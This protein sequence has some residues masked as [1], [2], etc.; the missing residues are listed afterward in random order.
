MESKDYFEK[1]M[2]DYNQTR[3]GRSLRKYCKDEAVDYALLMEFKKNYRSRISNA[4][5]SQDSCFL[6]LS[7]SEPPRVQLSWQVDMLLLKSLDGN[8][9]EIRSSSLFIVAELLQ[10]NVLV[11]VNFSSRIKYNTM[12]IDDRIKN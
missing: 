10:K 12:N 7:V 8:M 1:V 3:N 2:Q 4:S 5:N 6:P 9:V 11:M